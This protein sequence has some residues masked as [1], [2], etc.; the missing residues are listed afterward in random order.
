MYLQ[1]PPIPQRVFWALLEG[2]VASVLIGAGNANSANA[3]RAVSIA[4]GLPLTLFLVLQCFGLYNALRDDCGEINFFGGSFWSIQ[5]LDFLDKPTV[6]GAKKVALYTVAPWYGIMKVSRTKF[7]DPATGI[8]S[9]VFFNLF[10]ICYLIQPGA[11]GMWAVAWS[12][13]FFFV[14]TLMSVRTRLRQRYHIFGDIFSDFFAALLVPMLVVY[15]SEHL[16]ENGPGV[17]M[18]REVSKNGKT[19]S[20][21]EEIPAI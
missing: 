16:V 19:A 12:F 17:F 10:I 8:I 20:S 1:H 2:A 9:C 6:E 11:S 14:F 4:G 7:N 15:Q 13:F 3:L 5:L 21:D 18:T